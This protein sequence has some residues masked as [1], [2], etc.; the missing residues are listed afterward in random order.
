MTI[1]FPGGGGGAWLSNLIYC[2]E[3]NEPPQPANVNFH[4]HEKS[5]KIHVTHDVDNKQNVFFN[6]SAVFNMYLNVVVK[7]HQH[8][9]NI[10]LDPIR[11]QFEALA[12]E[13]S[14]KLMFLDER[15]DIV[16][17]DIFKNEN[18]FI[19]SV[20]SVL[21]ASDITYHKNY[22]II[23]QAMINYR[24]SCANPME[25]FD[26]FDNVFWLGWCNGICKHLW[27]DWPLVDSIQQMQDFLKP[28]QQFFKE[29]TEQYMLDI[30]D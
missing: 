8:I 4:S 14:S 10:D 16:W 15:S 1:V 20:Y 23:K 6:G 25:Y 28:K 30:N 13:S 7:V 27:Q 9:R 21:D 24:A 5:T 26:N 19:D 29:F 2:L 3:H 18:R 22:N 12:S 17:N 11:D